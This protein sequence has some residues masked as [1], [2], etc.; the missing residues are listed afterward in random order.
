MAKMSAYWMYHHL[1]GVPVSSDRRVEFAVGASFVSRPIAEIL[2]D[3]SDFAVFVAVLVFLEQHLELLDLA[4]EGVGAVFHVFFDAES[5][6]NNLCSLEIF[7][8]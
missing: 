7:T 6:G 3:E 2:P 8:E 1:K 5:F 4:G